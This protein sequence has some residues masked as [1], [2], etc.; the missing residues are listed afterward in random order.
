VL[1]YVERNPLRA[2]LAAHAADWAW[3]S[4]SRL[5]TKKGDIVLCTINQN[6]PFLPVYRAHDPLLDR[7]VA[8]KIP[9]P[10]R[11]RTESDRARA[12]R[13]AKAAAQLTHP[14]IVPVYDAGG[15]GQLFFIASAFI[16]GQTLA[17]R[18]RQEPPDLRQA[19]RWVMELA[20]ALDYAHR[21]GIVHRDVKPGNVLLDSAG[22][23]LLTD[24]GLARFLED[25]DGLTQDGAVMGTPAYMSPEQAEARREAVGPASD[26]YS[27][28]VILYELL[29]GQ[30]PFRGT[31]A[32][33]ARGVM[34]EEPSPPHTLRPDVPRELETVCL[35][36]MAK[37]PEARYASCRAMAEAL[38]VWLGTEPIAAASPRGAGRVGAWYRRHRVAGIAS[39]AAGLVVV[40]LLAAAASQVIVRL[41]Q[42]HGPDTVLQVPEGSEVDSSEP[43]KISIRLPEVPGKGEPDSA[44]EPGRV[45][46]NSIGMEFCW[47][48]FGGMAS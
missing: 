41:R 44:P 24:F 46:Q 42:P 45:I 36:A 28:G 10:A 30:L 15:E 43:G 7:E 11:L 39:A 34:Y 37:R 40:V 13:E 3:S 27:L 8:L 12:L 23:P 14:H 21:A 47:S 2:D 20:G 35:K 6:V 33:M 5:P 32:R 4:V 26:Q 18:M 38:G 22:N 9:H 48:L 19:A 17:A 29:T 31:P 16:E 25:E 1:R